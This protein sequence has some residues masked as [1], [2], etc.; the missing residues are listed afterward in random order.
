MATDDRLNRPVRSAKLLRELRHDPWRRVFAT[1]LG[2]CKP[3]PNLDDGLLGQLRV[4][5]TF[6]GASAPVPTPISVICFRRVPPKVAQTVV[7][8]VAVGIVTGFL[9]GRARANK[10]HENQAMDSLP[11]PGLHHKVAVLV[12]ARRQPS[13]CRFD[14]SPATAS[15]KAAPHGPVVADTV[16]DK[17]PVVEFAEHDAGCRIEFVAVRV[18]KIG[19][20]HDRLQLGDCGQGRRVLAALARPAFI[21]PPEFFE[22]LYRMN[23]PGAV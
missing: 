5:V 6:A 18:G 14:G 11:A 15:S 20:S 7:G 17:T 16:A 2:D 13:P 3:S 12:W 1:A 22:R 9:V 4:D 8:R 21:I 10:R 19:L 23:R